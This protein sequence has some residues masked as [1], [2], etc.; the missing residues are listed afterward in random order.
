MS[1]IREGRWLI[2]VLFVQCLFLEQPGLIIK[3]MKYF[4]HFFF[5][6]NHK[7]NFRLRQMLKYVQLF[8]IQ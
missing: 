1:E 8:R 4:T 3:N 5:L 7:S 2:I 6:Y